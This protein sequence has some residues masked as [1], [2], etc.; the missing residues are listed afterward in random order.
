MSLTDSEVI[1]SQDIVDALSAA[2]SPSQANP[3]ATIADL[4]PDTNLANTDLSL[5]ANREHRLG[6]FDLNFALSD[7]NGRFS[8]GPV[9]FAAARSIHFK[10]FDANG[11]RIQGAN[12]VASSRAL[13]VVN[14]SGEVALHVFND[15]DIVMASIATATNR[16][17]V[18]MGT[19][20]PVGNAKLTV[21]GPTDGAGV[22]AFYAGG[23]TGTAGLHVQ[24]DG[25]VGVGAIGLATHKFN[26]QSDGDTSGTWIAVFEDVNGLEQHK[27]RSDG[28]TELGIDGAGT[29]MGENGVSYL[30][31]NGQ[32]TTQFSNA[33]LW[34]GFHANRDG[35]GIAMLG[36]SANSRT[37]IVSTNVMIFGTD[38]N[39]SP[40]SPTYTIAMT[41]NDSDQFVAINPA[42]ELVNPPS[43]LTVYSGDVETT[44]STD[45]FI[46]LDRTNG[47]RY[48]IYTNGGSVDVELVV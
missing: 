29:R 25:R 26:V 13:D 3:F 38:W 18:M 21:R 42:S 34:T 2:S 17:R 28:F 36:S 4:I 30:L 23:L 12:D 8:V 35:N 40:T 1:L 14:N 19:A 7:N 37:A 22:A 32:V 20:T 15:S 9:G 41:I 31:Q 24:N 11:L 45:G 47:N 39:N 6:L 44:D 10:S 5:D 48:R 27:F 16:A 43:R 46:V 33:A